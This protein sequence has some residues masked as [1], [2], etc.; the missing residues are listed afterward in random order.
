[1]LVSDADYAVAKR[2]HLLRL[3]RAQSVI[4][5]AVSVNGQMA[6][7]KQ[8]D[9]GFVGRLHFQKNPLILV[10]ILKA[11]RP[12]RPSLC[13]IGGGDLAEELETRL[14]Q[15]GLREQVH[16]TGEC[17]RTRALHL[18][19]ACRLMVLPSRWEGHPIALIEAML[20]G[21]PAVASDIS[22]NNEIV[23]DG[24][25]GYLVPPTDVNGYADRLLELLEDDS[26]RARME[27]D[28]RAIAARDYSLDRMVTAYRA[29]Y[30]G[31]AMGV[32]QELPA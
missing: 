3:S 29:I 19:S 18:L 28:A 13:V 17:D 7:D 22:G 10:D 31:V 6:I 2:L 30:D 12:A 14:V 32:F 23:V 20:L 24:Q 25:T 9:I 15:E 27:V 4:K 11:M 5:N 1:M 8:Y 21:I 16:L 26:L